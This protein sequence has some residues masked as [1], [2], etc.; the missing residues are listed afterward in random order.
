MG[1]N[2]ISQAIYNKVRGSTNITSSLG[3][4]NQVHY[5]IAPQA[6]TLPY[7]VVKLISDPHEP[8]YYDKT[9]AGQ[10]RIQVSLYHRDKY[11]GANLSR[12]IWK[13]L[14]HFSGE[15][16]TIDIEW[17]RVQNERATIL[18]DIDSFHFATDFLVEYE[19]P[20]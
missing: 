3:S 17:I 15:A 5:L 18:E 13:E 19:D 4:A 12:T 11:D 7:V 8:M 14:Q 20:S 16:S 6:T 9:L 10:A 1:A 2:T